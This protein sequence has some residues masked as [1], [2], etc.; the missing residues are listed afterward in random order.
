MFGGTSMIPAR[1]QDQP[2]RLAGGHDV[3]GVTPDASMAEIKKAYLAAARQAHPDFHNQSDA[4]QLAAE[5][6]MR[7]ST[8]PGR[9]SVM[10]T[11]AVL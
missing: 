10:S 5:E 2:A 3:L 4:A 6:R 1:K 8:L 11:S 7:E 9:Y